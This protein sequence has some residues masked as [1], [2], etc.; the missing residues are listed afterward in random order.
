[1]AF[2]F[3]DYSIQVKAAL[4]ASTI[5]ALYAV[6]EE[7][8]SRTVSNSR[9][10]KYGRHDVKNSWR[11]V[12]DEAAGEAKVGTPLEAG[13]W[14]EFGT[15]SHA[16]HG[17]GRKGWWVY[18]EGNDTPSSNQKYYT[19]QEAKGIAAGLRAKGLDAHA[20]DGV[21]PNRPLG[22]AYDSMKGVVKPIFEDHLKGMG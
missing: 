12:V 2:K 8:R 17:D 15:G 10:V 18:V 16:A 9:P 3:E 5:A 4:N 14:E 1:M 11:S 22:R 19:E 7:F 13:Y 6:A 21:D 20:T